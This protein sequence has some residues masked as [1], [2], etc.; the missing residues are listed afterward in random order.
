MITQFFL[1]KLSEL[2]YHVI[3]KESYAEHS[4]V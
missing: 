2:V 4:E 1:V 3:T